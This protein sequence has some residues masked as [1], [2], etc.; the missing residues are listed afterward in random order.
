MDESGVKGFE[1]VAWGG[2]IVP[3]G[4]PKPIVARLNQEFT[5]V[6]AAPAL[7][8]KFLSMGTELM[9]RT[10]EQFTAHV[11]KETVKWADVIKRGGVTVD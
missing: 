8:E 2:I 9:S 3:G 4:V 6:V 7:K 1:I 5:R 10:P 11:R